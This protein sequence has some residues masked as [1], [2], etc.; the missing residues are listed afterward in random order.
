MQER[1][2]GTLLNV[3]HIIPRA[4]GGQTKLDNLCLACWDCNLAKGARVEGIDP[5]TGETVWLFHPQ[6]QQWTDHFGWSD[7][8]LY[9]VGLTPTGR[10]TITTLR[11]NRPQLVLSR[12]FWVEMGW[13]PPQLT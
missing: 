12:Q 6:R 1:L 3:D 7:D 10:A 8:G 13:H 2:V 9:Q 11:L 4:L 5:L